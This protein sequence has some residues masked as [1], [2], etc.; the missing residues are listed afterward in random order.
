MAP[1]WNPNGSLCTSELI[2]SG[3]V[4]GSVTIEDRHHAGWVVVNQRLRFFDVEEASG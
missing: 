3:V 1:E 4:D 2:F